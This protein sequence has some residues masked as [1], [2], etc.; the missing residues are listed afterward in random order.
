MESIKDYNNL[1]VDRK[2]VSI[3]T[4]ILVMLGVFAFVV[5]YFWGYRR[6][7]A[8]VQASLS[9]TSFADQVSYNASHEFSGKGMEADIINPVAENIIVITDSNSAPQEAA[10]ATELLQASATGTSLTY[11]AELI[12][13]GRLKAAQVFVDKMKQ[14]GY[15]VTIRKRVSKAGGGKVVNWYQAI[16][17]NFDDKIK[18]QQLVDTIKKTE[19][20]QD[21]KIKN[22]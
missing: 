16:T 19:H 14:K 5:G 15:P 21:I 9:R 10:V 18:L 8:E 1:I 6:A 11:Y 17:E 4:A 2:T 22:S 7:S 20:L 12:G 13:F 3:F